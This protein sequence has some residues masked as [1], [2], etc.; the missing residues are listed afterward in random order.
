MADAETK[1]CTEAEGIPEGWLGLDCGPKSIKVA[2]EAIVRAK[3]IV[4]NCPPGVFEFGGAF[5]TAT[6]AFVDAIAPSA[7]QGECVSVVGGGD[8]ATAV[9]EMRA[10]GKFTHVS[11]GA[12]LEL[13]EGRMLPGIA[14]LTDVS[15]MGDFVPQ[16]SS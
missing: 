2:V 1:L 6:S 11:T 8:T 12:S 3:T 9:A 16:W 5:A 14:A 13:V 4:W 15:E 10:E 7:Q